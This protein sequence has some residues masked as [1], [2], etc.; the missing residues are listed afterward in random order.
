MVNV[1]LLVTIIS[2]GFL[3]SVIATVS[4]LAFAGP[5]QELTGR[6]CDDASGTD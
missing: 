4:Y 6:V 5:S 1:A 3:V 2:T